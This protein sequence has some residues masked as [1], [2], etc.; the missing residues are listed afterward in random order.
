[1]RRAAVRLLTQLGQRS[2]V[3]GRASG[4]SWPA[5]VAKN[6]AELAVCRAA[7]ACWGTASPAIRCFASRS[8][9]GDGSSRAEGVG[10][11]GE[12]L[13]RAS[14]SGAHD[15][16]S[17]DAV[18]D[19]EAALRSDDVSDSEGEGSDDEGE[20]ESYDEN[21]QA[22]DASS[23]DAV[24]QI[25]PESSPEVAY[26]EGLSRAKQ[27]QYLDNFLKVHRDADREED[28]LQQQ[29]YVGPP[30]EMTIVDINRSCKVTK[31]GGVFSFRAMVLVG[32]K[33]GVIGYGTGKAAEVQ[34]AVQKANRAALRNLFFIELFDNHTIFHETQKTYGRTK[35]RLL[36]SKQG[37]GIKANHV[38]DNICRLVGIKNLS[39]KVVGSHHPHNTVKAVIHG[40]DEIESPEWVAEKRAV[41]MLNAPTKYNPMAGLRRMFL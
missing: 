30:F 37:S 19:T 11:D 29:G 28:E 3:C 13:A 10:N 32:N 25:E 18:T 39:A 4:G 31:A 8:D 40:L 23:Q 7:P 5:A 6:G 38:I 1:M 14:G 20:F 27:I 2:A 41:Y 24:E 26:L 34:A 21:W 16:S 9:G 15:H 35:V 33:A 12:Q 36:P 17:D 22:A